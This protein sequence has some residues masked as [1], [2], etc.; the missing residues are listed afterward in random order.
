M[1]KEGMVWRFQGGVWS[2]FGWGMS[3]IQSPFPIYPL[4][5]NVITD[6]CLL[7]VVRSKHTTSYRQGKSVVLNRQSVCMITNMLA[8]LTKHGP[9]LFRRSQSSR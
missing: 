6:Y 5:T 7:A 8:D 9:R 3:S 1:W 4:P 2:I